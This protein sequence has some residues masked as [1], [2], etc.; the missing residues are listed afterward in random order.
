MDRV[1]RMRAAGREHK[2]LRTDNAALA[3]ENRTLEQVLRDTRDGLEPIPVKG[4][5][6]RATANYTTG[7][8]VTVDGIIFIALVYSKGKSPP[9]HPTLWEVKKPEVEVLVWLDI[10]S[11][12]PFEV[13]DRVTHI[14]LTFACIRAHT[15]STVR[16]PLDGSQWWEA[17]T[18]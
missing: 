13:G 9:E 7:D 6:Y 15:K 5:P 18:Q 17:V 14:G 3:A 4:E 12:H 10:D 1:E 16:Q 11:G 2:Q 8:E